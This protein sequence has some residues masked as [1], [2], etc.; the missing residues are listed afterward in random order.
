MV[1]EK[2]KSFTAATRPFG[3]KKNKLGID[4]TRKTKHTLNKVWENFAISQFKISIP[5][6]N[7][8]T[9]FC[10]SFGAKLQFCSYQ[11]ATKNINFISPTIVK[12][13]KNEFRLRWN[14]FCWCNIFRFFFKF[15]LSQSMSSIRKTLWK[16]WAFIWNGYGSEWKSRRFGKGTYA[17]ELYE[18]V[19]YRLMLAKCAILVIFSWQRNGIVGFGVRFEWMKSAMQMK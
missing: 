11:V 9:P 4:K 12:F 5:L 7:V 19:Q 14:S 8:R 2:K 6:V 3:V 16:P 13:D 15:L 18:Y 10:G 17:V 1:S